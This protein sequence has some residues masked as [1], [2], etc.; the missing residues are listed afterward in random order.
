MAIA[1]LAL[2]VVCLGAAP[3]PGA[4]QRK[5]AAELIGEFQGARIF[6]QQFDIAKELVELHDTSV[7]PQLESWLTNDDR[8]IRGNAAF[9]FAALG[10]RRGFDVIAAIL[11]DR[12]D[13]PEG[14]GGQ[15]VRGGGWRLDLQI[16]QDR[17]YAVHLLGILKD[18]RAGPAL[19]A[20][21]QD[22]QVNYKVAWA[23]GEIGGSPAVEGLVKALLDKNP[24]VRVTA[25]E[26][27][28]K[29]NATEALP[30]LRRLLDDNEKSHYGE[31]V[32]V[33]EAAR[34]AVAKLEDRPDRVPE[35]VEC[36]G[37]DLDAAMKSAGPVALEPVLEKGLAAARDLER[38]ELERLDEPTY[39][40]V[41]SA[42]VGFFV[43][44]EE[45]VVAAP[46]AD[47]FL[48]LARAKGTAVDRAF[49]EAYKET[50]PDGIWPA[51]IRAQTD[52]SGCRVFDG[53][54]LTGLY[55]AWIAFQKSH[56][57][58]YREAAQ[59]ELTG[60]EEALESTCACGGEDGVR[61]EL[62]KF[63]KTF[64]GLPVAAEVAARLQAV[65]NH[66]SGIRFHCTPR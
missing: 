37:R 22:E 8:H 57:G 24:N 15:V 61:K 32:S 55:G 21:L 65:E 11:N 46:D 33:A 12:S 5:S 7:L 38:G 35:A 18:A 25:I 14:Q 30:S 13:R 48:K 27:L 43:S 9:I 66:T 45:I 34:A 62:E 1:C 29:L 44:R 4:Q 23:L 6:W 56:P 51:Y 10:D 17:F 2:P 42:M 58:Q 64:P 63:L 40:K 36:Y 19:V 50:Y 47:F 60:I 53:K 49:F 26:S 39:R 31:L 52:V 41:Q 54:T 28:G 16:T 20:L 59:K 3:E